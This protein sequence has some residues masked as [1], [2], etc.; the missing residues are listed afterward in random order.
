[1]IQAADW[2]DLLVDC[3]MTFCRLIALA[4]VSLVSPAA[5]DI[6]LADCA[7]LSALLESFTGYDLAA[8]PAGDAD[9]WCVLDGAS[10][11]ATAT[12]RPDLKADHLRLR[13]T[14]ANGVP[15]SVE[16]DLSGLRLVTGL[17]GKAIDPD[18][19]AM[20]RLQS[21][22]LQLA[23]SVNPATGA[24]EI[25]GLTLRL[26]GGTDLTLGADIWGA[27]LSPQ[28]LAAGKLTALDLDWRNDG[29]L[30]V[31]A[32]EAS[33][34]A[35]TPDLSRAE[36]TRAA[37][38]ALGAVV[39]AL[40]ASLFADDGKDHLVR[41]IAALPQGRGRLRLSLTS[42]DGIGAARLIVAG[43]ADAPLSP[44]TMASLFAGA[45]LSASWQ[46]GLAP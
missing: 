38:T 27:G 20:F 6:K 7:D 40:P 3:R 34:A 31:P 42:P 18:L 11:Q 44:E 9:G 17:G 22:D 46:P 32:M 28:S 25:R 13:G 29:R 30:L 4:A 45:S 43:M 5:A 23:A 33:G 16:L 41:L 39:D 8:P 19:Q 2:P 26:S 12:D 15:V 21:G 1:M 10:L 24:L 14:V 35:L 37:R 36:A